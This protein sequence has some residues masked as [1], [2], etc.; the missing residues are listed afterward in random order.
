[1]RANPVLRPPPNWVL[2]PKQKITSG[3]V[4]YIFA[5]FSRSSVFGMLARPGWI[6][7]TTYQSKLCMKYTYEDRT[8]CSKPVTEAEKK[9]CVHM[10]DKI[11]KKL[12]TQECN[13]IVIMTVSVML[14]WPCIKSDSPIKL[15]TSCQQLVPTIC[16]KQRKHSFV[17]SLFVSLSQV[18]CRLRH[19]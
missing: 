13:N 2:N 7:S 18:M 10:C 8:T 3:V 11:V 1:M 14:K 4:L 5:S 12:K 17:T 15:V 19:V 9:L 16:N 6:I